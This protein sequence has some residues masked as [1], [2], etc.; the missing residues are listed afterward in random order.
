[1]G[2]RFG[3][4]D[5]T[6]IKVSK[7]LRDTVMRCARAEGLTA[8]EFLELVTAEHA[9]RRRFEAVRSAYASTAGDQDYAALTTD[10]D[11]AVSD[12]LAE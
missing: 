10:W 11:Q 9:R 1:M 7:G 4:A 6:T 12:G 3:M 2:Y 5:A 8:A